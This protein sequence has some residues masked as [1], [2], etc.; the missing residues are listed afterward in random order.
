MTHETGAYLGGIRTVE[1]LRQRSR[2]CPDSGCWHWGLAIVQGV[3]KVHFVTPD[4][5]K[6]MHARGRRAALYLQRGRDLKPGHVAYA[7]RMCHSTDCVN[8]AHC[9]SG[10]RAAHGASLTRSGAIA[11]NPKRSDASRRMWDERGRKLTPA[12]VLHIRQSTESTYELA[13]QLGV[14]QY[15]IWSARRHLN[16]RH[17]MQPVSVFTWRPVASKSESE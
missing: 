3:P 5:G 2:V 9:V 4:T 11:G 16:H 6:R 12:M 17:V 7:A 1:C 13:R 15:T 14:A 10:N 8:P